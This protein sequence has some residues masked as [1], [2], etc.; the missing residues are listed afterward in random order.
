LCNVS[1]TEEV[2]ALEKCFFVEEKMFIS[3]DFVKYYM[4]WKNNAVSSTKNIPR[5]QCRAKE[6][7]AE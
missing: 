5:Q 4:S 2:I 1:L 7:Y 3:I 6:Q